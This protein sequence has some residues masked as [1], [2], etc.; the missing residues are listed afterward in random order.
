MGLD[1][2]KN[3]ESLDKKKGSF[4]GTRID[5]EH[6]DVLPSSRKKDVLEFFEKIGSNL[7]IKDDYLELHVYDENDNLLKS[8]YDKIDFDVVGEGGNKKLVL[9]PGDTLR[10]SGYRYGDYRIVYNVFKELLGSRNGKKVYIEEIS[11]TRKEI[12]ILPVRE[13]YAETPDQFDDSDSR[14]FD[15]FSSF[16]D[17]IDFDLNEYSEGKISTSADSLL[18]LL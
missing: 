12:R 18:R 16:G 15:R 2:Y 3:K 10:R 17:G 9:K 1:D 6:T 11:S 7:T 5:S 13:K 8:I 14:F 4:R